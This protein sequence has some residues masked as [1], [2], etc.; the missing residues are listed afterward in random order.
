MVWALRRLVDVDEEMEGLT[1]DEDTKRAYYVSSC[2]TPVRNRARLSRSE[3][4][5]DGGLAQRN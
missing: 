2:S 3:M 1:A 5:P 4:I